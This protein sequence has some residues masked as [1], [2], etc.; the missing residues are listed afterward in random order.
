MCAVKVFVLSG[1]GWQCA[2]VCNITG[3][4]CVK[5]I[6]TVRTRKVRG[7]QNSL[8]MR[9]YNKEWSVGDIEMNQL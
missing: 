2:E 5:P 8:W 4:Q 9:I 1:K 6:G 7:T 3:W